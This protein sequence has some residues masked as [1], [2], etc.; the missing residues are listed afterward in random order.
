MSF[1]KS[2]G[3]NLKKIRKSKGLSQEQLAELLGLGAKS[4]SPIETGKNFISSKK[5]ELL[6]N[7]LETSPAELFTISEMPHQEDKEM[8]ISNILIILKQLNIKELKVV[9]DLLSRYIENDKLNYEFTRYS[10]K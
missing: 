6:C 9:G 10:I 4:I 8:Y 1:L 7:I 3:K 5:L 2:F